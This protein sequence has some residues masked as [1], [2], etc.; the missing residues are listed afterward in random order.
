MEMRPQLVG[1][2]TV[3]RIKTL[4]IREPYLSQI[5]AGQKTIEVRVGYENIRRLRPGDLLRL[6]DRCVVTIHRVALYAN[7]E[8][9]VAN[10]NPAEIAPDLT[11]GAG[12]RE[13][14]E[15][16]LAALRG[17]Y[18]P[19]KEALGAVALEVSLRRYEAILLDM[20]YT[21]VHFDPPQDMIVQDALQAAGAERSVQQ[22]RAA[23]DSVWGEH[24]RDAARTTFPATP[25]YDRQ[26]EAELRS[27]FLHQ[28]GL[29]GDQAFLDRYSQSLEASFKTPGVLRPYREVVDVLSALQQRG[30]RLGIVSNW[31]WNLLERVRQVELDRFFEIIWAS[32]YAGCNKP[33]PGIFSQALAQME[34]PAER[35]LY[36]GDSYEHDVVGA[37]NAGIDPVLLDRDGTAVEPDCVVIR[38]L[39]GVFDLQDGASA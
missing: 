6:N 31:S 32:A 4:W 14:A 2:Q 12:G 8:E 19:E 22:I 35:T 5:L 26:V 11:A 24:Y 23:V 20:G 15:E 30:Y 38:D 39:W 18:S 13:P 21:L 36:I 17:I 1:A 10:E 3:Q 33:H 16:Q 37:R 34:V 25:E 7:F 28:L 29:G 9:L 27:A